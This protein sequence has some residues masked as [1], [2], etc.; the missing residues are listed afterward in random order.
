MSYI[1]TIDNFYNRFYYSLTKIDKCDILSL[2]R[3]ISMRHCQ[4][5][6]EK[7]IMS[8]KFLY[9]PNVVG[10]EVKSSRGNHVKVRKYHMTPEEIL[11]CKQI[12]ETETKDVPVNIKKLAGDKFFN[13][14]R[15]GIY[16]GQIQA[17][18]LL[19]ANKWHD[20]N[21]I[22]EKTKEILEVIPVYYK[23]K[24]TGEAVRTNIWERFAS[25]TPK[26]GTHRNRDITGRVQENMIFFQRLTGLHPSGFKLKQVCAS[27]DMK[28][29]SN[30]HVPSGIYMYRLH[31]YSTES[32]AL[33]IRDFREY[34]PSES[35]KKYISARFVGKILVK[36]EKEKCCTVQNAQ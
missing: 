31:T 33:P 30:S 32:E 1:D 4:Y 16:Y 36:E 15:K 28:K 25:K 35:D 3:K 10:K 22:I 26:A 17:M 7:Y 21:S 19:G 23:N 24:K 5:F 11:E 34:S 2:S 6:G 14:Y 29:V 9:A 20:L 18:Y 27:V 13:P 8:S 12:F